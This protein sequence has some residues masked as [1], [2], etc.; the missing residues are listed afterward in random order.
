[1]PLDSSIYDRDY[2]LSDRCEGWR[3]FAHD[4]GLSPLKDRLVAMLEP[5]PGIRILD[6]GCGRGEVL[7]ACSRTGADVAGIDYSEAAVALTKETLAEAGDVDV[8]Q[9]DVTTL[10]WPAASF[11]RVL[12][13][14]VI[15]HLDPDQVEPALREAHRVLAPGG[16]LV[17]HTSPNRL[18]LRVGWP[19]ARAA[20]KVA[21]HGASAARIADWIEQSKRYHTAEQSV[22]GLRRSLR[23]A[24]FEKVRV[25]I[26]G[27]VIRGGG[28]HLV[29]DIAESRL[30]RAAAAVASTRPLRTLLGN[31]IYA[32]AH[33]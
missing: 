4:R 3:R 18:F 11:D 17:I 13:G 30:L 24:G 12:L 29:E 27:D 6:A 20:L 7:L 10:S 26:D 16:M 2:Y 8:R 21:G 5:A 25:W 23:G 1:M 32:V 33:R 28:H 9:G 31:D 22:F 15:E 19:L 14:D